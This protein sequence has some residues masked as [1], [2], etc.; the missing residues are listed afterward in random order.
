MIL[1]EATLRGLIITV[2][3]GRKNKPGKISTFIG[4]KVRL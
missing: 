1:V 4:H 2:A 3:H